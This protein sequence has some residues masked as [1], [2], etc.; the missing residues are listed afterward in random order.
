MTTRNSFNTRTEIRAGSQTVQI[1]SLPAL[2]KAGFPGV[3][4]LPY[5]MKIL[6]EN[7]LRREDNSFV[8]AD[9]IRA[10]A[11]WDARAGGEKEISFMPARVLLQDFTGV[12]CVVDLAAMRD[13]IVAL[14]GDPDR[15]NPL[16]P[17]E[18]VIDHSVQVDYFGRADAFSLNA[19][20]EFSRNRE[21]YAFLRW[22]QR[23][24]NNFQVVPPDTGIVHQVNIEYLARVV[25]SQTVDGKTVAYPDTLVG[26]D[27]HTTMVNGLGVVGWGVGGIEAEAAMLGQPISMLIPHVVGFRLTGAMPQGATAT[28]L[29][30]TITELLR[31]HGVVGKFVEF[32][33][34]G[35]SA[36]T[37][38]DRATLGNMCPEY[39][40][41]VAIFP[42]DEMTLDYLRL[43][44]REASQ[45]ALVE[46]YAMAQGLFRT[47]GSPDAIYSEVIELDLS[48][49]EP[50]LAGPKRP[51][52]RVTLKRAKTAFQTALPTMQAPSKPLKGASGAE[53]G[54]R[55]G[56]AA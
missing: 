16:Q 50:S 40:A 6:L 38:A 30:L 7:L 41:T 15:V 53:G 11:G 33:G 21:R 43:T 23:A 54:A 1:Y 4:R 52:D 36:L 8:K 31:K 46:Q 28:D 20:L 3:A 55:H 47:S 29:V 17:V 49:I 39:G 12:P 51:Q 35:L 9:D 26:T 5:S 25:F 2:E 27:S 14:G 42:I 37:I 22:G 10:V 34:D 13:A 18:L 32:F 44:G 45:I 19:E 24:F 56:V 48:S